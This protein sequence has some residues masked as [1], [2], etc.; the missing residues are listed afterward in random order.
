M[1]WFISGDR[2]LPAA[3][4]GNLS[5]EPVCHP[6][7]LQHLL[8][9]PVFRPALLR[10]HVCQ[11]H[12]WPAGSSVLPAVKVR[13]CICRCVGAW[14]CPCATLYNSAL[15]FFRTPVSLNVAP[16]RTHCWAWPLW[17]PISLWDCST[18]ANF[19]WEA[20]L[21]FRMRTSCTGEMSL[22]RGNDFFGTCAC[23]TSIAK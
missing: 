20:T 13:P 6:S 1:W 18:Y 17:C 10:H 15:F 19:T 22:Q 11:R 8:V 14:R 4:C 3:R 2:T 5:L 23:L 9:G 16:R 21:L 12:C 7:A